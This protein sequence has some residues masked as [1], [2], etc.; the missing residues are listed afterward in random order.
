MENAIADLSLAD[1]WNRFQG[2]VPA[3][4]MGVGTFRLLIA[5][6]VL[7]GA[8]LLSR[9]VAALV[10]HLV[11]RAFGL[12]RSADLGAMLRPP[13]RLLAPVIGLM[14][15]T[16][17]ILEG[18]R[19]A[20]LASEINRSIIVFALFWALFRAIEPFFTRLDKHS[21]IFTDSM[22]GVAVAGSRLT[23]LA[24]GAA[25]I[26]EIWGIRVGP[27]IAGFGLVGA[28]VA[29][30]AQDLFKNLIGGIFIIAERRFQI[31]DWISAPGVCEGTVEQ[32]GLRTTTVRQFD[33]S[34]IYVPNSQLS[35]TPVINYQQM[36]YRRISWIVGLTYDT[37]VGQLKAVRD[38]I[39][40]FLRGSGDF[41]Q[42]TDAPI[43]VRI[44]SFGDSAI[45]LMV[46]C[47]TRTTDWGEWLRVKEDLACKISDIVAGAGS[48]FAF[49]SQSIYVESLPRGTELFTPPPVPSTVP[50]TAA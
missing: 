6:A 3:E 34:P 41:V 11:H 25:T 37:S 22:M 7:A 8:L 35:D 36:T 30:G 31:G 48:G 47:F 10:L 49:P 1:L 42:T 14:I 16:N 32:I 39:E 18:D 17:L 44:D 20:A 21:T 26:L 19:L 40:A 23:V 15:V 5:L 9:P 50:P 45:N 33:L 38:G 29:L 2:S 24:L 46:Y 4:F 43:F 13:A 12:S 27:I 28:A